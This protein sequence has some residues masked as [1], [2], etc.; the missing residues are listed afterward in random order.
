[1]ICL[2]KKYQFFKIF[3]FIIS[4]VTNSKAQNVDFKLAASTKND[5]INWKQFPTFNLPFTIVYSGPRL[6]DKERLPLKYGFSHLAT[7][8]EADANL[9]PQNRALLWYGV[10]SIEGQPWSAIKSPWE[11]DLVQYRNKWKATMKGFADF[12]D[13]S[14]NTAMPKA[15]LLMLDIEADL[16]TDKQI[17]DLKTNSLV[18]EKYKNMSN[19]DFLNRY[20]IDMQSL[21]AQ[22]IEYVKSLGN[23][24][25]TFS[26]YNDTP[27]ANAE[28]PLLWSW[29]DW[30]TKPS[31]VHYNYQD[32]SFM[33]INSDFYKQLTIV[34]PSNYF[35]YEYQNSPL[36]NYSNI[37]YG[38][39]QVEANLERNK[40][41]ILVFEWLKFNRCQPLS[42]YKYDKYLPNYLAEAQAIFPFF[43]GAKG[44]WLWDDPTTFSTSN[45]LSS[46]EYFI[47]GLYKLSAFQD[48]F[49]GDYTLVKNTTAHEYFTKPRAIWR[50]VVKNNQIL[51]AAINEFANE[52]ETTA[53][54][55]TF[56]N[57]EQTIFLNGRNIYLQ[58]FDLPLV[59][60]NEM[61][62][63]N[64]EG[65]DLFLKRNTKITLK[66]YGLNAQEKGTNVFFNATK[67]QINTYVHSFGKGNYVL[68]LV[69][70]KETIKLKIAMQ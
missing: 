56:G 28:F 30:K 2:S 53:L 54:K 62:L 24:I 26:S 35:C 52:N 31:L 6:G 20:K 14:R 49:T 69:G 47:N 46:Y 60:G 45:N 19:T 36:F 32:A 42:S 23:T 3:I 68:L 22:P 25:K 15:D 48:F 44:I 9:T 70:N 11:N 64:K 16:N 57:W 63:Q 1:M 5:Q 40:K 33:T 7:F 51:I 21:Y 13:D 37:A 12:F 43:A 67:K 29:E 10:A 55:V 59:L 27:I 38:M 4:L 8:D 39:F 17:L 34:S 50:A 41:D 61:P 66:V 58:K 65:L 18:P